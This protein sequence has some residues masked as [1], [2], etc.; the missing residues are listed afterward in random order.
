MKKVSE[1]SVYE[2]R[3]KNVFA[4]RL[5]EASVLEAQYLGNI[6]LDSQKLA[7][8]KRFFDCIKKD[9][10]SGHLLARLQM[11]SPKTFFFEKEFYLFTKIDYQFT[12]MRGN[13]CT[14]TKYVTGI[15]TYEECQPVFADWCKEFNKIH[16]CKK[17]LNAEILNVRAIGDVSLV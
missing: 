7:S 4:Y 3:M 13:C 1:K 16:P 9:D 11:A 5:S 17:L 14:G 12:S 10:R 15:S 2:M 6:Y 8:A